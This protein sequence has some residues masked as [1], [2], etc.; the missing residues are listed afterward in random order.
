MMKLQSAC[1]CK[2]TFLL[3]CRATSGKPILVKRERNNSISGAV[4]ST[5]SK[6]SVPIGFSR[7]NG[8][9]SATCVAMGISFAAHLLPR[10]RHFKEARVTSGMDENGGL[11]ISSALLPW[12]DGRSDQPGHKLADGL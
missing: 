4:Y 7:P 8:P 9:F 12:A 11:S 10:E 6:P 2:V 3:L 1:L 5:N